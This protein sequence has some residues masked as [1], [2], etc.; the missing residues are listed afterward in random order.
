MGDGQGRRS[1]VV[2]AV[3]HR[4]SCVTEGD[5]FGVGESESGGV[6]MNGNVSGG[7]DDDG[8]VG[9]RTKETV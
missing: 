5:A 7:G 8:G 4:R 2:V 6:T 9:G 1:L 3:R